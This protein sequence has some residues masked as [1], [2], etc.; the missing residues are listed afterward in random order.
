M[1][2]Y[3]LAMTDDARDILKTIIDFCSDKWGEADKQLP[4]SFPTQDMLIGKKMA[5]NELLQFARKLLAERG[6]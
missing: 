2:G 4:T 5:F 1:I 3:G 6:G